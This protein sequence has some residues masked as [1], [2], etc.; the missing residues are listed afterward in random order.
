MLALMLLAALGCNLTG[1]AGDAAPPASQSAPA[2]EASPT[3]PPS[4]PAGT[5]TVHA[6]LISGTPPVTYWFEETDCAC[7]G[8][9]AQ[10]KARYGPGGLECNTA[11]SGTY[12][13]DNSTFLSIDQYDSPEDLDEDFDEN[14]GWMQDTINTSE[15]MIANESPVQHELFF[16]IQE[17]NGLL[18][19]ETG[20]GGGSSKTNTEIP[21]CGGG[22]GVLRVGGKFLVKI[23]LF[24]CDL[25]D[26]R[27][28]YRTAIETLGTCAMQSIERAVA[29]Q[30]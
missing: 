1:I 26:D 28:V 16:A 3:T 15:A 24:A 5:G 27:E 23:R 30:P 12:I 6:P 22:G 9:T 7:A 8:F 4:A 13:D 14:L 18:Y 2:M 11:W 17:P 29:A 25:G 21:M 19:V 20:P 10:P